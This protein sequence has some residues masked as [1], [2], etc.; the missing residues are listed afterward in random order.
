MRAAPAVRIVVLQPSPLLRAAAAALCALAAAALG[1]WLAPR[2]GLD[3]LAPALGAAASAI[4][5]AVLLARTRPPRVLT[6]AWDMRRWMLG[7]SDA[8]PLPGTLTVAMD[9]GS[10]LLLR[11]AP[12]QAARPSQWMA[13][14]RGAH[15]PQWHALRCAVY[16][17]RPAAAPGATATD[18]VA[19]DTHDRS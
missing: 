3:P 6:L 9:L 14:R 7:A 17:P 19:A 1:A 8:E 2:A 16:S 18:G 5:A 15:A 13:L 12:E 4:A 11:F 10:V